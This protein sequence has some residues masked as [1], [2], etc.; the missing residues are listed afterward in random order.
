[1][2]Q[3][4]I[5]LR[6]KLGKAME[7]TAEAEMARK[8]AEADSAALRAGV[9]PDALTDPLEQSTPQ[10]PE[11]N[12]ADAEA[13]QELAEMSEVQDR[14]DDR[15]KDADESAS[16]SLR[17]RLAATA[18]SKKPKPAAPAGSADEWR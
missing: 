10:G 5:R 4:V 3:E 14:P 2:E 15:P 8:R 6:E 17:S 16:K 18:L 12:G 13:R 7:Q 11:M 9:E 1:M